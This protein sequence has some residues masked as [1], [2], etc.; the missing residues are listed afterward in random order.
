MRT[1]TEKDHRFSRFQPQAA[2]SLTRIAVSDRRIRRGNRP[3]NAVHGSHTNVQL[4]AS[5][6]GVG[7]HPAQGRSVFAHVREALFLAVGRGHEV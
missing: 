2:L 7:V 6:W 3:A 1:R 4:A 5:Q